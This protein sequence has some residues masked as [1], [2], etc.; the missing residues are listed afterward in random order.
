MAVRPSIV[1][2][3]GSASGARR[4]RRRFVGNLRAPLVVA[5]SLALAVPHHAH[6]SDECVVLLHG[7]ARSAASMNPVARRL[8]DEGYEVVNQRYPSRRHPIDE[9]AARYVPVGIAACRSANASRIHFVTHSLGGILVRKHLSTTK[10]EG[11]GRTVMLA[12]PNRGSEVVDNWKRVPGYR[13][14]NGPAGYQ[15]GT[16]EHSIP[17][18]LGPVEYPVGIIAG[19]RSVNLLLSR[20]LPNPDDGKV[21]VERTKVEGMTDHIEVPHSHPFIMRSRLVLDQTVHFLKHGEFSRTSDQE[22]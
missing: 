4:G 9:L 2:S 5:S 18:Q 13:L 15:L 20:S 8:A 14:L 6:A 22:Y 12:P 3:V 17:L 19:T 21:S 7:L 11:L 16:D 1:G 10:V